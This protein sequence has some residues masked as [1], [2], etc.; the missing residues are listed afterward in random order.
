MCLNKSD[1]FSK[2]WAHTCVF[3]FGTRNASERS[4]NASHMILYRPPT[5]PAQYSKPPLSWIQSDHLTQHFFWDRAWSDLSS[6]FGDFFNFA[7][8]LNG[9]RRRNYEITYTQNIFIGAFVDIYMW[10]S[11]HYNVRIIPQVG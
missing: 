9:C 1:S 5:L 4:H 3:C 2:P 10:I 8:P 11:R 6:F 7:K